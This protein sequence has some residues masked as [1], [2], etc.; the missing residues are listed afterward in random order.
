MVSTTSMVE[1]VH[2]VV[3]TI[4]APEQDANVY[5]RLTGLSCAVAPLTDLA[6]PGN[7]NTVWPMLGSLSNLL[8]PVE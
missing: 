5:S 3:K 4:A 6:S 1:V 7:V 8:L 2:C